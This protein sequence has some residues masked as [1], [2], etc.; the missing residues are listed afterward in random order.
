MSWAE[1][2]GAINS[3]PAVP[4][5]ELLQTGGAVKIVKSVQ[6]GNYAGDYASGYTNV[7]SSD[8]TI[9]INAVN[10]SKTILL[11]NGCENYGST[12]TGGI[13]LANSTTI[14]VPY[15]GYSSY[16]TGGGYYEYRYSW[17]KFSWQVIEFY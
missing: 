12:D 10:P 17:P 2:K 6:R 5:N 4:L 3:N 16:D 11:I 15:K 14:K 7:D 1:V 8:R 13:Y 9:T